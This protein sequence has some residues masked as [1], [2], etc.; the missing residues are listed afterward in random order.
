MEGPV[1]MDGR[2]DPLPPN[3][4]AKRTASSNTHV[5]ID[6]DAAI[7]TLTVSDAK[8]TAVF[9][10]F[11][12]VLVVVSVDESNIQRHKILLRLAEPYLEG[13]SVAQHS[14]A[15][16][17]TDSVADTT[18]ST[19]STTPSTPAQPATD[20]TVVTTSTLFGCSKCRTHIHTY[21]IA[22][23]LLTSPTLRADSAKKK[24]KGKKAAPSQTEE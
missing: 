4:S 1:Y 12:R 6:Y 9:R 17:S 19:Q 7:P 21:V 16:H 23:V 3:P 8:T 24:K 11:T 20:A 18:S 14:T 5:S 13:L 22:S 2:T 10:V 15:Q